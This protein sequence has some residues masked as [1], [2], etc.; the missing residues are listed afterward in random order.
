MLFEI[1][2][3]VCPSPTPELYARLAEQ[4]SWAEDK[5]QEWFDARQYKWVFEGLS[6]Q[7]HVTAETLLKAIHPV[8]PSPTLE[9]CGRIGEQCGWA[10]NEVHDWFIIH[11]LKL[12]FEGLS[13]PGLTMSILTAIEPPYEVL[14]A[15]DEWLSFCGYEKEDVVGGTL[16]ILQGPGTDR[17]TINGIML[18]AKQRSVCSATLLN[19]T[20]RG[21]P[22]YHTITI[23]P[24]ADSCGMPQVFRVHSTSIVTC[25][26]QIQPSPNGKLSW[27]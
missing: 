20:R 12:E 2:F 14:S 16:K 15:S 4:C 24:L 6:P 13:F 1:V 21:V 11:R 25:M 17:A 10:A 7:Y 27:S 18:A 19:Y 26:P 9:L 3:S 5:V 23:E 22:F 8:L